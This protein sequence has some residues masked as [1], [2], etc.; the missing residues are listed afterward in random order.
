ML[1][2]CK[3]L[4]YDTENKLSKIYI[5]LIYMKEDVSSDKSE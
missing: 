4:K 3:M 2:R 5:D 1:L